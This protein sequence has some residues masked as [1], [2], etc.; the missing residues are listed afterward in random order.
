MKKRCYCILIFALFILNSCISQKAALTPSEQNSIDLFESFKSYVVDVIEKKEDI[1]DSAHLKYIANHY[2]FT[3]QKQSDTSGQ[4]NISDVALSPEQIKSLRKELNAFYNFIRPSRNENLAADL[5][6]K[7]IRK[8]P[9][10]FIYSKLTNFQKQNTFLLLNKRF[11]Q[12][13]LGYW[14][15]MPAMKNIIPTTRIWSWTLMYEFGKYF[16][17]ALTGEEGQEY[18]FSPEEFKK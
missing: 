15:F 6:L 17:R 7:P 8:S 1:N 4:N 2:M 11:P 18:I 9:D 14:L 13:V 10:T 3:S 12:K 5:T 16:F